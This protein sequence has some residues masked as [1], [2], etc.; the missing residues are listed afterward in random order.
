MLFLLYVSLMMIMVRKKK[1]WDLVLMF[2]TM[3][4]YKN[5]FWLEISSAN[6]LWVFK[7][8]ATG[9]WKVDLILKRDFQV[10]TFFIHLEVGYLVLIAASFFYKWVRQ[11]FLRH[12]KIIS[13][14][15]I[16]SEHFSDWWFNLIMAKWFYYFW[17]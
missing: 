5:L 9:I 3:F 15:F 10:I 13:D 8:A 12:H 17:K 6:C 16:L 11:L 7:V 1:F 2:R 14:W 4:F